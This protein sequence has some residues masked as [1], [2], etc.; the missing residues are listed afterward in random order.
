MITIIEPAQKKVYNED[1]VLAGET[2][3]G[4]PCTVYDITV[5]NDGAS[6]GVLNISDSTTYSVASRAFKV[7]IAA[8]ASEHFCFPRG[9]VFSTGLSAAA[10]Q[11]SINIAISYD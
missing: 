3:I 8:G 2:I 4:A 11:G 6:A 10:N 9:K 5:T 1:V 7:P